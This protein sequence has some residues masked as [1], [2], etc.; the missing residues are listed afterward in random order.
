MLN[1]ITIFPKKFM[2]SLCKNHRCSCELPE[3]PVDNVRMGDELSFE[4]NEEP[5]RE[6]VKE[7]VEVTNGVGNLFQKTGWSFSVKPGIKSR[8]ENGKDAQVNNVQKT[9]L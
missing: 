9:L 6:N 4:E 5:L 1:S 8:G 2:R 7:G 3:H